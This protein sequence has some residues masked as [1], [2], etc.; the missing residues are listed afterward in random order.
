MMVRGDLEDAQR[1]GYRDRSRPRR[2]SPGRGAEADDVECQREPEVP[3]QGGWLAVLLAG[4]HGVGAVPSLDQGGGGAIPRQPRPPGIY[5]GP[6]RG[7]RR[8]RRAFRAQRLRPPAPGGPRPDPTGGEGRPG[9]RLLG[10]RGLRRRP[11]QL[12]G[13]DGGAAADLG[14]V[15]ARQAQG[16]QAV[17]QQG[18]RGGLRRVDRPKVQGPG[19]RMDPGGRSRVRQ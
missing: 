11:R 4:R 10:P 3:G 5:G 6:G 8:V 9:Q 17:V 15:L 18:E 19:R 14:S 13:A 7:D 16:R 2:P 12:Q 1:V